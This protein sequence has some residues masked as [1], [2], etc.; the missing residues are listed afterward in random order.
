M[1]NSPPL[2]LTKR[3]AVRIGQRLPTPLKILYWTVLTLTLVY[4]LVR[5]SS[6][7][8]E[9]IRVIGEFIFAKS[10]YYVLLLAIFIV[11]I[12]AFLFAQLY[13]DLDPIGKFIQWFQ[14]LFKL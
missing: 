4:W 7:L 8:L 13:F 12:G 1:D 14:S 3:L 10:N 11:L 5:L 2:D 9:N 6:W